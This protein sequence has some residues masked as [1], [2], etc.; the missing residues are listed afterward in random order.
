[1]PIIIVGNLDG[2]GDKA[3]RAIRDGVKDVADYCN[4]QIKTNSP[5]RSGKLS[6]SWTQ[7]QVGV[8][9]HNIST[10]I[11]YASWVNDGTGIYGSGKPITPKR[12]KY[13]RFEI[14]GNVIYAKS[15]KGQRGQKYV[16][17]TVAQTEARAGRIVLG[18]L[19]KAGL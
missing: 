5:K 2:L 7:K 17:R 13:L 6:R 3:E 10:S 14:N 9:S 8:L 4:S 16:E 15:V 12:A 11:K 19:R 1:M 18:A